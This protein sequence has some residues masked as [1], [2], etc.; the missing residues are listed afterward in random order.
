M[1][2][3]KTVFTVV[4]FFLFYTLFW[5]KV[6]NFSFFKLDKTEHIVSPSSK[7]LGTTVKR[8]SFV[9]RQ[10][11]LSESSNSLIPSLAPLPESY[12]ISLVSRRQVFNLSCEF[13]AASA[14]IFHYTNNQ[15]F[16]PTNER[17]A[18]ET[19]M[20]KVGISDNPNIGVRMG[21]TDKNDFSSLLQNLNKFF[22]GADYY[23]VHAPPFIDLF[24]EY[25]LEAKL[26]SKNQDLTVAIQKAIS[27]EHLII[28]WIRI[29]YGQ[30]IDVELSYGSVPVVK[31][32][33]TVVITGYDH[34]GVF[35]LD[36]ASG[37]ERYI[38][39]NN[40]F[41]S[42]QP[43]PLPFLEVYPAVSNNSTSIEESIVLGS[44][45][46]LDR[47]KLTLSILNGAGKIGAASE[48]ID[49][50]RDFGYHVTSTGNA[51]NSDYENVT[52]KIKNS[53]I[54]YTGLLKKDLDLAQYK[55]A[56]ISSDLTQDLPFDAVVIIGQ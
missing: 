30:P 33:H 48:A 25:G 46:G 3:R 45:S 26:L 7:V 35:I 39:Y 28:T 12:K 8:N 22:G 13:A 15:D 43:F 21:V 29:G 19:L 23:G 1:L 24:R 55:I 34:Q 41:N 20:K 27:S 51:E 53:K 42:I 31:G 2:S 52:I 49:I 6:L 38:I 11:K 9:K 40:L 16:N 50:L 32:E 14:V 44:I 18:E 47:S 36:P 56:S 5:F 54:D 10:Q 17:G 37:T 4:V